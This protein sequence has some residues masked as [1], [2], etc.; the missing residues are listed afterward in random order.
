[1][2][3]KSFRSVK[4]KNQAL[5]SDIADYQIPYADEEI[6]MAK[7]CLLNNWEY[8]PPAFLEKIYAEKTKIANVNINTNSNQ[9]PNINHTNV[10]HSPRTHNI[11]ASPLRASK[12][13]NV[14]IALGAPV[15]KGSL[16][17]KDSND[18][19]SVMSDELNMKGALNS[20]MIGESKTGWSKDIYYQLINN[21]TDQY[22]IAKEPNT[23]EQGFWINV[24][25]FYYYFNSFLVLHN[26]KFYKTVIDW[27]NNWYNYNYDIFE[28]DHDKEVFYLYPNSSECSEYI[29]NKYDDDRSCVLLMFSPNSD[30]KCDFR[31]VRFYINFQLVNKNGSIVSDKITLSS[32]YSTYQIDHLNFDEEYYLI[33]RGGLFPM[34]FYLKVLSDHKIESMSYVN[35]L[36]KCQG[37]TEYIYKADLPALESDRT[38]MIMKLSVNVN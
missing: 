16:Q 14:D 26:P 11:K 27:D 25:D 7:K 32:Y 36:K 5:G 20:S 28:L 33:I 4:I 9:S 23:R 2:P 29:N 15:N 34:G 35:Y 3:G 38:N 12:N 31:D 19:L 18:G 17:R 22:I 37:Y 21:D 13:A 1:M 8:P 30:S 24:T 10:G 6:E